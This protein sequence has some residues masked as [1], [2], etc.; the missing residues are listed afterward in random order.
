MADLDALIIFAK[1][2]EA[3]GFSEA[4]RRLKMP[5]STVSRRIAELEAQLGV[6]LLERSTRNLRLTDVGSDVLDHAQRSAELS[7]AVDGIVSNQL[8]NVSGLL[9]LSAPP[10]ISDT[11]LAP[12][13]GAFQAS[14]PSVRVRILV[15][16][17]MIDHIVEGID[18]AFR[19]GPLK[20]SSLVARKLLSYR[21]QLVAS[22]AYIQKSKPPRTP[23][24]LLNHR[25]LSFAHRQPDNRW[26][27]VHANGTDKETLTFVPCLAMNDYAGLASALLA[28]AGICDLPPVVQPDLL[29]QGLLVEIMP[30]WRFRTFD[31]SVVHLGNRHIPRPVRVFQEFVVQMAPTLFPSLPV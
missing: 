14:Y 17:R 6:R 2:V 8:A 27:F 10:S 12:L 23:R 15:T 9:R 1:V 11:L 22:P 21:H 4:A 18:L 3:N 7:D 25:L 31:L 5:I 19:L 30:E 26:D 13:V 28:G 29:R 20:D 24:D 16:D